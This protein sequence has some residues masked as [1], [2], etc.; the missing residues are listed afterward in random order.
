MNYD[1]QYSSLVDM[2]EDFVYFHILCG[3]RFEIGSHLEIKEAPSIQVKPFF[4]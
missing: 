1:C 2:Y 4:S 3:G